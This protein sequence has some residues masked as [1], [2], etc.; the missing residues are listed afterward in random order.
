MSATENS[1][2]VWD[3]VVRIGHWVLVLGFFTAYFTEDDFLVQH[4]WT[5]YVLGVVVAIRVLWGFVGTRR[6]R[7]GDFVYSP[8]VV[9]RYLGGLVRS[10]AGRYIGH[11]P[12]GGAMIMVLLL[13]ISGTVVSG[14]VLYA[15][16]ENA[17]PLKTVVSAAPESSSTLTLISA[18]RADEEV[19]E[20]G[21]EEFWEELHE[22]LA[23]LTLALVVLHVL[24]VALASR[25]H[26]E[27]L[28]KAMFSGR[29]RAN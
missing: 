3:P 2:R 9:L 29:K 21:G 25:V 22:F 19:E 23:N 12:A 20:E 14:L 1:I 16:E 13:A 10:H 5:G 4:V 27:N 11:S 15:I 8:A 17:G 28:V 24:G 26:R 6:A 18:A 7:F